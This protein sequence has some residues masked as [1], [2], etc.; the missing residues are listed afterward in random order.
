[1]KEK[2]NEK[3]VFKKIKDTFDLNG[4]K[5]VNALSPTNHIFQEHS[6]M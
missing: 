5:E 6:P 2:L 4:N 1:M 3:S